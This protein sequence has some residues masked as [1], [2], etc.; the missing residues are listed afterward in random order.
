MATLIVLP[1]VAEL[2]KQEKNNHLTD[3][4]CPAAKSAKLGGEMGQT[5]LS[6]PQGGPLCAIST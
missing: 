6:A 1:Q 5:V 3:N 2:R 4:C